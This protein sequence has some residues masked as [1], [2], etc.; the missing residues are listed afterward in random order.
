VT[1]RRVTLTFDNGPTPGV[2][3]A[4]LDALGE[5]GARAIF[6][7][8]GQDLRRPGARALA[9][10]AAAAGHWIGNHTMSHHEQFGVRDDPGFAR[11]EIDAAQ[12]E[13]GDLAHPDRLF[14]PYGGGGVLGPQVLSE[15]ALE[16]LVD[17]GY[18]CVLWN[19][20]PRDWEAPDDWVER[21]LRDVASHE[22]T[23]VVLH[24]QAT[25]AMAHLPTFLAA[26]DA[27][28][29]EIAQD[30]PDDCVPIRRGALTGP[31]DHLMPAT[32]GGLKRAS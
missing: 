15:S 27:G 8:V 22:H 30:L 28:G 3:D 13:L 2:T 12:R 4:V 9:E 25:G 7:V 18:T 29:V 21:A 10:R 14:R 20:V 26:L 11:E 19:S 1:V 31:V 6:F 5:H 32:Y 16:H 23:V 24:D 17:G